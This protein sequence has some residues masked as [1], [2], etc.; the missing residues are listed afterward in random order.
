ML[1]WGVSR[2]EASRG[3]GGDVHSELSSLKGGALIGIE[4][5]RMNKRRESRG[6]DGD[7]Y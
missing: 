5:C 6:G 1:L 7:G 3:R 4:R 2:G